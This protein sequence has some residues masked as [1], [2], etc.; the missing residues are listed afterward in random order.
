MLP[1]DWWGTGVRHWPPSQPESPSP[2]L[3]E[4]SQAAVTL[5]GDSSSSLPAVLLPWQWVSQAHLNHAHV[6]LRACIHTHIHVKYVYIFNTSYRED[7]AVFQTSSLST[8]CTNRKQHCS[9][10]S[11]KRL[12]TSQALGEWSEKWGGWGK[13]GLFHHGWHILILT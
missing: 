4:M 10:R 9:N 13:S 6:L 8:C 5:L 3:G 2:S 7:R 1:N 12:Q 11:L